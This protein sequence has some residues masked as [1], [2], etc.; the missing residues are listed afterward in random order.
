MERWTIVFKALGNVNRL[1]TIKFLSQG[2]EATVTEISDKLLI[3]LK[4]TSRHLSI[5]LNLDILQNIGKQGHV[6]YRLSSKVPAD[7]KEA[8]RLFT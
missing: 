3:S 7:I 5:L 8:L 2:N 6:F 4:A 1:K